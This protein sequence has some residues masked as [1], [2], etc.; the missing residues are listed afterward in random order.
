EGVGDAGA[1]ARGRARADVDDLAGLLADHVRRDV[2]DHEEYAADI[3]RH[4]L[5]PQRHIDVLHLQ[6]G[7]RRVEGGVVDQDVDPA[8]PLHG[9]G[10]QFLHLRLLAHVEHH[11]GHRVG[12]VPGGQLGRELAAVGDVGDYDAGA[13]RRYRLR[14]VASDPARP[15]GDY[16]DA[17]IQSGHGVLPRSVAPGPIV[18]VTC[19]PAPDDRTRGTNAG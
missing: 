15:A 9:P 8:E 12:A 10:H 6:R 4:H 2:L 16:G 7:Q 13:F 19:A 5:V 18:S 11:A 1:A 14:V 3:D 17:S